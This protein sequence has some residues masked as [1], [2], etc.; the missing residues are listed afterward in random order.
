MRRLQLKETACREG[1]VPFVARRSNKFSYNS[2]HSKIDFK[3]AMY[4]TKKN[5]VTN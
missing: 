3:G 4:Y 2:C 5:F 1:W